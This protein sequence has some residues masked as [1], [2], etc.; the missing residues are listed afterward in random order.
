ML[1]NKRQYKVFS[2]LYLVLKNTEC[3]N[4]GNGWVGNNLK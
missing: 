2:I 4:G 3:K 1:Y